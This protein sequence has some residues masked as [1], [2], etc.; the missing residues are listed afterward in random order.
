M[1]ALDIVTL[2]HANRAFSNVK[3]APMEFVNGGEIEKLGYLSSSSEDSK[4]KAKIK[5]IVL[6]PR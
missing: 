5:D 4:Q 3:G 6:D 1:P 2:N